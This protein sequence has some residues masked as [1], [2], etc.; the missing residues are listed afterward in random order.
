MSSPV[1]GFTVKGFTV[2]GECGFT[3]TIYRH[4]DGGVW[5]WKDAQGLGFCHESLDY[6]MEYLSEAKGVK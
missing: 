6:I 2:K 3:F 4:I 5:Y 1:K